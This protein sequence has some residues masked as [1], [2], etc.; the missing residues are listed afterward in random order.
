MKDGIAGIKLKI[1]PKCSEENYLPWKGQ[2]LN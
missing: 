1:P 2:E